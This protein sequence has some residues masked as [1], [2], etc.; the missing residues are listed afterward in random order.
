MFKCRL[1]EEYGVDRKTSKCP[2]TQN[3]HTVAANV[4]FSEFYKDIFKMPLEWSRMLRTEKRE[5]TAEFINLS[6]DEK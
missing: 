4:E 3:R 1:F 5:V 6:N 2:T